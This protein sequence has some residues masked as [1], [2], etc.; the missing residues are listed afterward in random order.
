[1]QDSSYVY[2][3]TEGRAERDNCSGTIITLVCHLTVLHSQ[4]NYLH[5]VLDTE[6][7]NLGSLTY[8]C[9]DCIASQQQQILDTVENILICGTV[10]STRLCQIEVCV[11][12]YGVV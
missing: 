1:M 6:V 4:L 8:E 5:N 9:E 3:S 7:G 12:Y 11:Q 10:N 2:P